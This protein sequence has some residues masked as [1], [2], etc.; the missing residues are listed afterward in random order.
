M[1]STISANTK[2]LASANG[3]HLFPNEGEFGWLV[4]KDETAPF[5][6]DIEIGD[7]GS[8][9]I[10]SEVYNLNICLQEP[11]A[12]AELTEL[13]DPNINRAV[14]AAKALYLITK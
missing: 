12:E 8:T 2:E 1:E 13:Q 10:V 11:Y 3:Y 9:F 14:Q 4:L 6:V 5:G 7:D